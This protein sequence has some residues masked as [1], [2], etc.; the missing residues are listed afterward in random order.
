MVSP[1]GSCES[2]DFLGRSEFDRWSE[3]DCLDEGHRIA[4]L[5]F[6]ARLE[7]DPLAAPATPVGGGFEGRFF[8]F[9]DDAPVVITWLVAQEICVVTLLQ[10]ENIPQ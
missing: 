4:V 9:L 7:Q 5:K 2:W 8:H 3:E 6:L 1:R 10:I